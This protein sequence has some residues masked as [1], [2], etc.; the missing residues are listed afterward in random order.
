M[1]TESAYKVGAV[2]GPVAAGATVTVPIADEGA[3]TGAPFTDSDITAVAVAITAVTPSQ[4]L[5][6]HTTD[7]SDRPDTSMMNYA[8]NVNVTNNEIVPVGP[9]G[10]I[11][12]NVNVAA[13]QIVVDVTGYFTTN[14][15][16]TNASTY[17]PLANSSRVLLAAQHGP[18]RSQGHARSERYARLSRR[19]QRRHHRCAGF[20]GL[21][22][23]RHRRRAQPR[24]AAAQ[25]RPTA[26]GS[27]PTPTARPGTSRSQSPTTTQTSADTVIVPVSTG[28]GKINIYNGSPTRSTSS[29]TWPATSPRPP[30]V[31]TTTRSTPS[32]WSTPGPPAAAPSPPTGRSGSAPRRASPPTTRR[33]SST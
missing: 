8:T 5:P 33:W 28:D 1:D 30:P 7:G 13:T 15:A 11:A 26:A 2:T 16:A 6:W 32:T 21:R 23:H 4:A 9:D 17:T 3:T 24:R 27:L 22:H 25:Q 18:W 19:Q 29:A 14:L 12:I 10:K 31:S 20:P